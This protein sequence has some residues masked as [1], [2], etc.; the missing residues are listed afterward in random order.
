MGERREFMVCRP[1]T[2]YLCLC[3]GVSPQSSDMCN[4]CMYKCTV[5]E[6]AC[7]VLN[8]DKS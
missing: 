1:Y 3:E 2:E 4:L 6:P 7:A 8:R 5:H